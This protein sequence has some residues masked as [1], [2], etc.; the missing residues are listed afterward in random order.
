MAEIPYDYSKLKIKISY[1]INAAA[2]N[3]ATHTLHIGLP[4]LDKVLFQT[5]S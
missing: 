4:I 3:T 1:V 5:C 2:I